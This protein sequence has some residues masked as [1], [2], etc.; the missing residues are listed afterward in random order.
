ME[1]TLSDSTLIINQPNSCFDDFDIEV[2]VAST[3]L[4]YIELAGNAQVD[5]VSFSDSIKTM[6]FNVTGNS[7][8][9]SQELA[10]LDN[11]NIESSDN[12]TVYIY[13]LNT[14]NCNVTSSGNS[15]VEVTVSDTLRVTLNDS[16]TVRY[17]GNPV[18][19]SDIKD[20]GELIDA[21]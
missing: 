8:V 20:D 11:I 19:I 13:E 14:K 10:N 1:F 4:E 18:I 16:P 7:R 17:K 5:I 6:N 12:A 21:N 15:G 9:Q 2:R 3:D